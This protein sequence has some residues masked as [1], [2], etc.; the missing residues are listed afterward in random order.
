MKHSLFI[1]LFI[2]LLAQQV[3]VACSNSD[4]DTTQPTSLDWADKSLWYDGTNRLSNIDATRPDVIYFLPTCLT[5]WTD[6]SGATQY[7]ADPTRADHL[8]AW[9]LS[10]ELADTI[11]STRANLFL[12]YYRQ[13]VFD[14]LE[15]EHSEAAWSVAKSDATAAFDYYLKHYNNGRPFILAGYSQG[16]QMVK[17]VLKHISDEAYSRLIAAYVV[18]YGITASDTVTQP[19]HKLSHIKLAEDSVSC[20][21]TVNFNSVTTTDA[22]SSLLCNGNIGC[23]NPV[24]WTTSSTAA[25]LLNAGE[26]AK[27][28]DA[29]FPYGTAVVARDSQTPVTVSVDQQRHV[30]IVNG[31]DAERYYLPALQSF[32]SVGNLHLQELFFYGDFLRRNVILRSG[33][34]KAAAPKYAPLR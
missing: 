14:A 5:A 3:C 23:I 33:N 15:G 34:K 4:G 8:E 7:N 30:L 25:T 19:G 17:E 31:I 20:G 24:S 11:F 10:A 21:V 1:Q 32:F 18:G 26:K 29:R 28:D 6:N 9:R 2:L 13:A 16:G 22:I 12:P 27:A